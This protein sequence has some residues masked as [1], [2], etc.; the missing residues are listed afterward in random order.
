VEWLQRFTLRP[1]VEFNSPKSMDSVDALDELVA[2]QEEL[3]PL[4]YGFPDG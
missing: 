2:A 1:I 4:I 3:S